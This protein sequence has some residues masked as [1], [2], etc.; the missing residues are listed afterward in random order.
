[1]PTAEAEASAEA[2]AKRRTNE[3]QFVVISEDVIPDV[4]NTTQKV[5]RVNPLDLPSVKDDPSGNMDSSL[6]K[7]QSLQPFYRSYVNSKRLRKPRP[8]ELNAVTDSPIHREVKA[9][10]QK[11][12][13]KQKHLHFL[14]NQANGLED[15]EVLSKTMRVHLAPGAYPVYYAVAKVNG[16]FGKFPIKD[17]SNEADFR[18]YLQRLKFQPIEFSQRYQS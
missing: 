7:I 10:K 9:R 5:I 11:Q 13:Q 6:F 1:A 8:L 15:G 18:K 16:R 12:Q 4:E 14:Y 17:F 2:E 3:P